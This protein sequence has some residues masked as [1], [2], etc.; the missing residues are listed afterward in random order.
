MKLESPSKPVGFFL[1]AASV[2][3]QG[4]PRNFQ[5]PSGSFGVGMRAVLF[6][7]LAIIVIL[8]ALDSASA[9]PNCR[10]LVSELELLRKAQNQIIVGLAEN[11]QE[12]GRSLN[13]ISTR[14]RFYS[15]PV[16]LR[17]IHNMNNLASVY[18]KRGDKAKVQAEDLDAATSELIQKILSCLKK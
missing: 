5:E 1:P 10:E 15:K 17:V 11:H 6:S 2:K 16:P 3:N 12:I 7:G 9:A 4:D 13:D 14:L 8:L 18:R